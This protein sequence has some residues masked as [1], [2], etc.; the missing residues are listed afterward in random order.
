M[1]G[2]R[3]IA[4]DCERFLH[5]YVEKRENMDE[6]EE[7]FLLG[8]YAH[9]IADAEYQRTIRDEERVK[10]SWVRIRSFPELNRLSAG[11]EE[12]FDS[13]KLLFG[14][15]EREKDICRIERDYLDR[16]PDSG[17][18]TDILPLTEFPD[19]LDY[20]PAGAIPRKVK[21]MGYM[22][23]KEDSRY[24]FVW[25]T[26]AEYRSYVERA[27]GLAAEAILRYRNR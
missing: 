5:E 10:A 3:K 1:G 15:A 4:G 9:L 2:K 12:T 6:R 13:V 21:V 18:L 17:Y 11:M 24:P 19:Y 8:Y 20:L 7:S 27:T 25:M 14:K 22:P 16:H 23:R 26:E